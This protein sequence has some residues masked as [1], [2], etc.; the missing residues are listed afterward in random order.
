MSE[1]IDLYDNLRNVVKNAEYRAPVPHNLNKLFVH[2]WF[3]N[4]NGMFLLQQRVANTHRFA[5]KWTQTGGCVRS[6]ETSFDCIQ[7]ESFEE[8]G[9]KTDSEHAIFI[10]TV[11]NPDNFVD[12]WLAFADIAR[13]KLVLQPDEVQDAKWV[14]ATD[15]CDMND[16]DLLTPSMMP[17][18]RMI[19]HYINSISGDKPIE[20]FE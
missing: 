7:R 4:N 20:W 16:A 18:L 1:T 8:L 3:V 15:I 17:E 6:G 5:N 19:L 13:E 11:K 2:T 9:I 12:V 10:G 14:N